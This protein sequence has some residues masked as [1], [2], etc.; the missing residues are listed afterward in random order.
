ME[1]QSLYPRLWACSLLSLSL[2]SLGQ[3]LSFYFSE[4]QSP[5]WS[6]SQIKI[7]MHFCTNMGLMSKS[8]LSAY[9]I[10]LHMQVDIWTFCPQHSYCTWLSRLCPWRLMV[11][12]F[13]CV[14]DPLM[15]ASLKT[16]SHNHVLKC[17]T[18]KYIGLQRKPEVLKRSFQVFLKHD[19]VINVLY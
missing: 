3:S 19:V 15:A 6:T 11:L 18:V 14:R 16:P 13:F 10:W 1:M 8:C 9:F 5:N 2:I 7:C 17:K 4:T 12:N